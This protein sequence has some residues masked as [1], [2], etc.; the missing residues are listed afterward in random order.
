[1]VTTF[2]ESRTSAYFHAMILNRTCLLCFFLLRSGFAAAQSPVIVSVTP[3]S[4]SAEQYGKFEVL[5]ELN[6]MPVNPYDYDELRTEATFTA[7][8]G[9]SRTVD[10]FYMEDF[11][12]TNTNTGALSP[13]PA[14]GFRV[15][16]SP[17]QPG[18]WNYSVRCVNTAGSDTSQTL[19]FQCT[20]SASVHN[21][22]FIRSGQGNHLVFTDGEQYI[23]VG[24]NMAWQN[25]NPYVDYKKWLGKLSDNGGNFI[26]LWLCHWGMGLEWKQ[27]VSGFSGLKKYK[28][29][30]SFYLDWIFD[31]CAEKGVYVML[32]LNHHGQVSSQVNPNWSDN[33]Y[34]AANGGPC[35]G[36]RDFFTNNQAKSLHKN[37]LRYA[38][39]RW[40]YQRSIMTWELFNEVNWTDNY[41]QNKPVIADWHAEMAAFIKQNDPVRRPVSTSYGNPQS[42]DPAVW[43][44]PD[45]DYS[46]RHYYLDSPN[47][48]AVL[49]AGVRDNIQQYDKPALIGEFGLNTSGAGL[50]ALDPSGIHIHNNL[51]GPLF[52]GGMGS[53]MTWWWDNY[54]EP[55]NLYNRFLGIST[56]SEQINFAGNGM[57]PTPVTVSGPVGSLQ[58]NTNLDWGGLGDTLIQ[59]QEN[60]IISPSAY[61]LGQFLY[62]SVWNTQYRR[63]PVFEVNM[64]LSGQFVIKVGNQFGTS[65]KLTV[66]LNG[67]QA[68][69]LAPAINQTYSIALP[70]GQHIIRVDNT[71]TD[72]MKIAS[73]AVSGIGSVAAA[74]VLASENHNSLAGWVMNTNYNHSYFNTSG[75]PDQLSNVI[76]KA[77]GLNDGPYY[78][79]WYD[80]LTGALL[81]TEPVS[82]NGGKLELPFQPFT[83]DRAFLLDDQ[84]LSTTNPVTF[85]P[86]QVFPNPAISGNNITL[87]F[88]LAEKGRPVLQVCDAGG[89]PV[90]ERTLDELPAGSTGI[91]VALPPSLK[92]GIYWVQIFNGKQRASVALAVK[93]E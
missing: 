75:V 52:G 10:G 45:M 56:V 43:N 67:V 6:S 36:T 27:N 83:W 39:A 76:I 57:Q 53:G 49:S 29:S 78:A 51:W 69:N 42:E 24:E 17:T 77:D 66:W 31:H 9:S 55:S 13:L 60:G 85:M 74:Y 65:P 86:M 64:P 4:A 21:K 8:D 11:T 25:S 87:T 54:I 30:S 5:I 46:Q 70:Q 40:G 19:Q 22:G 88:E 2:L 7:P 16:F 33:P 71:G 44:N 26:R 84:P 68:L 14:K 92:S 81:D 32:C 89:L 72:W 20:P 41:E 37:R 61:K 35:A 50:A 90:M 82:V 48:E 63:P 59:V 62:G 93:G 91:T 73:Y 58:L 3:A 12:I 79:K 80:C 23:P 18:T 28:Q 1:M 15:R 38:L 34:N 47:L